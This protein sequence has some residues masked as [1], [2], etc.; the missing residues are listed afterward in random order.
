[1][2]RH[3]LK[4]NRWVISK[5]SLKAESLRTQNRILHRNVL[6]NNTSKNFVQSNGYSTQ[7]S[8]K[9]EIYIH[10]LYDIIFHLFILF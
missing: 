6:P 10:E 5:F 3:F 7:T 4:S 9:G 2:F 8:I 1:M